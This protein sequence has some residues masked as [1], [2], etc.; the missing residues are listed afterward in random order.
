M[1]AELAPLSIDVTVVEPGYFRTGFLSGDA[2]IMSKKTIK[3]Y[4]ETAAGE[5]R[6]VMKAGHNTQ[7]GDVVKGC[8]IIVDV[9]TKA[10]GKDVPV[11]VALGSDSPGAI[12]GKIEETEKLLGEWEGVTADTD[13]VE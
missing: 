12:R 11:R 7:Q 6:G 5:A 13:H 2:R 8:K 10:G 3:E 4:G 9:M 1:R